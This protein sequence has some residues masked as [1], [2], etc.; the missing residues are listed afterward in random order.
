M[1]NWNNNEKE[2]EKWAEEVRET[3]EE[4]ETEKIRNVVASEKKNGCCG[5]CC[6]MKGKT[7]TTNV[8]CLRTKDH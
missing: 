5:W 3:E 4:R 1:E 2:G 8:R 7:R 6:E